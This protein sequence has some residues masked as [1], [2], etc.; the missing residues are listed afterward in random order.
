MGLEELQG[1]DHPQGFLDA[2]AERQIV[3]DLVAD[4]AA[5]VDQEQPAEGDA[6]GEQDVVRPS[7]FKGLSVPLHRVWL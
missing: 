7:L 6:A 5:L 3:D 4:D 1:F 2:A